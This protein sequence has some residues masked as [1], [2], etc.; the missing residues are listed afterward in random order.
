MALADDVTHQ[1]SLAQHA[2]ENGDTKAVAATQTGHLTLDQAKVLAN[3]P[4]DG[5]R[6]T[7]NFVG[8]IANSQLPQEDADE[9]IATA[10][11]VAGNRAQ[12]AA[13][14]QFLTAHDIAG[15]ALQA[16]HKTSNDRVDE[17]MAV[18]TGLAKRMTPATPPSI[19]RQADDMYYPTNIMNYDP[20]GNQAQ[21]RM[22]RAAF[23]QQRQAMVDA[24]RQRRQV[25][26]ANVFRN[27]YNRPYP[28]L[29]QSATV[30]Q[31]IEYDRQQDELKAQERRKKK[32]GQK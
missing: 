14:G 6:H 18:A 28:S 31:Q 12:E 27:I 16:K 29:Y 1:I 24:I 15:L 32:K 2:A 7:A 3:H 13:L 9:V 20:H 30:Q 19:Q 10:Q 5:V 8:A 25:E 11:Q 22:I 17:V 26:E 4:H 21:S 23:D